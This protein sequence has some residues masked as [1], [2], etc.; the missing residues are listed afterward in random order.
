MKN[1]PVADELT[2]KKEALEA[3]KAEKQTALEGK[4]IS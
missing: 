2:I 1:D 4:I 3:E